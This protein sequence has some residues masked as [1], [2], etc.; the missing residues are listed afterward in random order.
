VRLLKA[1][2]A[3][4][5]VLLKNATIVSRQIVPHVLLNYFA[6]DDFLVRH[7]LFISAGRASYVSASLEL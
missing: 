2:I 1:F 3:L 7:A 4:E 5:K 6:V